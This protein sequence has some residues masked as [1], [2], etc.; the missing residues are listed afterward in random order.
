MSTLVYGAGPALGYEIRVKTGPRFPS[1]PPVI[2]ITIP[3]TLQAICDSTYQIQSFIDIFQGGGLAP[4][5]HFSAFPSEY[6]PATRSVTLT[7]PVWAFTDERTEDGSYEVVVIVG[8]AKIYGGDG[9]SGDGWR[10]DCLDIGCEDMGFTSP[11]PDDIDLVLNP[12][13]Q[14]YRPPPGTPPGDRPIHEGIDLLAPLNTWIRPIAPGLITAVAH[15]ARW[16]N[17]VVI[18]HTII[19]AER[20]H[21]LH[22]LYA[23]LEDEQWGIT[24]EMF[25]DG[26]AFEVD[27]SFVFG[28]VGR[29]GNAADLPDD[30]VHLHLELI[31][32]CSG[33]VMGKTEC[34]QAK[35]DPEPCLVKPWVEVSPVELEFAA[36]PGGPVPDPQTFVVR[37]TG[38]GVRDRCPSV[39]DP[40]GLQLASSSASRRDVKRGGNHSQYSHDRSCTGPLHSPDRDHKPQCAE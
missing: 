33:N 28:R 25:R 27:V 10:V 26:G 40:R 24:E 20:T 38:T 30:L 6:D 15:E 17:F 34:D 21:T 22:S 12:Q 37:N 8:T 18:R 19:T 32:N 16:G 1:L 2:E 5:D 23:H 31:H 11:F 36:V 4:M 35:I 39:G 14:F 29:S 3:D 7:V 9:V 13:R